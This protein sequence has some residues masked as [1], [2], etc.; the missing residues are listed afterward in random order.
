MEAKPTADGSLFLDSGPRPAHPG[1]V[2][3]P[4][5]VL[6]P[7]AGP[8]RI[9]GDMPFGPLHRSGDART[10]LDN[11]RPSRARSGVARTLAAAELEEWL[12]RIARNRGEDDLLQIRD[13]TREIA[14]ALGAEDEQRRLDDLIAS[15]LGTGKTRL[16][17]SAARARGRRRPFDAARLGL[18]E[19]LHGALAGLVPEL[20]P[21]P[22]DPNR[23]FAPTR[24]CVPGSAPTTSARCAR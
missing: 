12:E 7:R 17:T 3:L 6:R 22:A 24:R 5:L 20:R 19:V 9:E 1:T 23:V 11:I 13:E 15:L 10:A 18:F 8:G 2:R 21:E 4:G 14:P 16:V